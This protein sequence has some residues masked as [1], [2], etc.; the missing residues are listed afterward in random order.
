MKGE[1]E[2]DENLVKDL[3]LCAKENFVVLFEEINLLDLNLIK[4]VK[5]NP[6]QNKM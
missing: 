6:K 4:W 2:N 1:N 3:K 5:A